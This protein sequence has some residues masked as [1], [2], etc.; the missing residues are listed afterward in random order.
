MRPIWRHFWVVL[1]LAVG[2][3]THSFADGDIPAARLR[4]LAEGLHDPGGVKRDVPA[5]TVTLKLDNAKGCVF[6][7]R[8]VF[9][10]DTTT[11]A[12]D[13]DLCKDRTLRLT[14]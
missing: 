12:D 13:M 3:S 9:A 6:A 11:E 5:S 2:P 7:I 10:D 14:E 1:A 8:G 4:E